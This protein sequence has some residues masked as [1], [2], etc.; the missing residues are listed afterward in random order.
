M[1]F[2][3]SI[4]VKHKV[5]RFSENRTFGPCCRYTIKVRLTIIAATSTVSFE[6]TNSI[7]RS[8][9]VHGS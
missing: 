3:E 8:I 9:N 7:Y 5:H 1:S 6:I 4:K 2:T